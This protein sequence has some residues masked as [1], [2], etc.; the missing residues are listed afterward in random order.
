MNAIVRT[1][2]RRKALEKLRRR[3]AHRENM[4]KL[5]KLALRDLKEMEA[6]GEHCHKLQRQ[7]EYI[8]QLERTRDRKIE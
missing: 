6:R 5:I 4:D 8:A 2:K 7:N 3:K 1:A